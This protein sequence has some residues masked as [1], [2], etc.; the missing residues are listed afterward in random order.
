MKQKMTQQTDAYKLDLSETGRDGEFRCPK[1]GV[2]ISPEDHSEAVYF[3]YDTIMTGNN[4]SELVLQCKRCL[5]L[6]H[7]TGF[8]GI[9]KIVQSKANTKQP[10]RKN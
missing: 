1:C 5:C 6:I 3:I 2:H 9:Q 10:P 7:L 8:S 4:L